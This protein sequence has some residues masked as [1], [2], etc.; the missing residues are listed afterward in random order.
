MVGVK[1]GT[2]LT[3]SGIFAQ[4]A[5]CKVTNLHGGCRMRTHTLRRLSDHNWF[6]MRLACL[7]LL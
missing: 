7:G 4:H 6:V 5:I 2:Y 3:F 1:R